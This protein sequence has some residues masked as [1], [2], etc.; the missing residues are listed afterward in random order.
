MVALLFVDQGTKH[1]PPACANGT[2]QLRQVH[3]GERLGNGGADCFTRVAR[4]VAER[5]GDH[6]ARSHAARSPWSGSGTHAAKFL[7]VDPQGSDQNIEHLVAT[8]RLDDVGS[9]RFFAR[10]V[11]RAAFSLVGIGRHDGPIKPFQVVTACLERRCKPL[12]RLG[13]RRITIGTQ[14]IHRLIKTFTD[15][16]APNAIDQGRG[17]PVGLR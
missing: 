11:A 15:Q 1:C 3:S 13:C 8:Q 6:H 12:R 17:E 14:V 5:G 2:V 9:E 10:G 4:V 16:L 7:F